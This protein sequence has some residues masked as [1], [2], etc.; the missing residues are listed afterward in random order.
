MLTYSSEVTINNSKETLYDFFLNPHNLPEVT[1][2]DLQLKIIAAPDRVEAGSLVEFSVT[3]I[4]QELKAEHEVVTADG[5]AICEKQLKGMMKSWQHTRQFVAV[6]DS[7]CRI[8]NSIEFERPGG[9]LGAILTEAKIRA[10]LDEGFEYQND[11]LKR[12][13][14]GASA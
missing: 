8:E 9:L 3:R 13:F 6:S 10:M 1:S 12:K 5:D 11:Q 7:E 4:G 14:N 2:P